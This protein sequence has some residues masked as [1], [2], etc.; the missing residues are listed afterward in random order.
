MRA[1]G[2]QMLSEVL[3]QCY[4]LLQEKEGRV[5]TILIVGYLL[6]VLEASLKHQYQ[7]QHLDTIQ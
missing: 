7:V 6:S 5:Y 4:S 1:Q 2:I 3:L